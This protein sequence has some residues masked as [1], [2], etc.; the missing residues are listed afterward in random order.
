MSPKDKPLAEKRLKLKERGWMV[1]SAADFLGLSKEESLFI[2]LKISIA[3]F[4]Q[5]K[6]ES[7]KLTQEQFANLIN[8]SQS[9][10]AKMEKND[11]SV[12]LDLMVKS[13]L[14]LG[15]SKNELARAIQ[16]RGTLSV[17]QRAGVSKTRS[18]TL[19]RKSSLR[20]S[21]NSGAAVKSR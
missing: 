15:T 7:K 13:L 3:Q 9:R 16:N 10:V 5:E 17:Q 2:E 21:R 1:G 8:S 12:S 20:I 14:A 11:P 4:L 18:R 19:W 6:R